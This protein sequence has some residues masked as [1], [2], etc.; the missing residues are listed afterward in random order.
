M[1]KQ[2]ALPGM[3]PGYIRLEVIR[4]D[5]DVLAVTV[6]VAESRGFVSSASV[7]E[8][9]LLSEEEA[10]DVLAAVLL[11]LGLAGDPCLAD[12]LD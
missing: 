4:G 2:R 6:A 5:H 7:D 12:D 9:D 8:Y 10:A 11:G 1:T 3:A